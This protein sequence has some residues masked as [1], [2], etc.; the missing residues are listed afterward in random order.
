MSAIRG[1]LIR[2][3]AGTGHDQFRALVVEDDLDFREGLAHLV[4]HEGFDVSQAGTLHEARAQLRERSP[5]VVF[6]DLALPD[7]SGF[8]LLGAG[9]NPQP[10]FVVITG[11][12]TVEAVDRAL[13]HGAVDFLTKPVDLARL[14]A[15]LTRLVRRMG[16]F[17]PMLGRS[18]PMQRVYDLI[19]KIAP[20]QAGVLILGETGTGKELVAQ[21]VHQMSRRTAGPFVAVNCGAISPS[22]IES[23]LFGHERGSFTG[24]EH[25][26]KGY[27]EAAHGGTLL[28]DEITEMPVDLQVKLLRVIE[29]GRLMRV[30]ASEPVVVDVRVLAATNRDPERALRQGRL[31]EDLYWRLNVF[32]IEVPPLRERG[33]DI[34]MLA[35]HFLSEFN[36]REGTSKKWSERGLRKLAKYSWPG[37]VRE[38]RNVVQRTAIIARDVVD[39]P[40]LPE[41]EAEQ[42][43]ME[44]GSAL[45]IPVGTPLADVERRMILA[46][47]RM[48]RGDKPE[49]ARRLGISLKTLYTRLNL[50]QATGRTGV[51][52]QVEPPNPSSDG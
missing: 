4:A 2:R 22:V 9:P 21:T 28:L 29:S 10:D 36:L 7:G 23:E 11:T 5:G 17:G 8:D 43:P 3:A 26:R 15:I 32:Q 16:R 24:A 13:R 14:H 38:L 42:S 12:A 40:G 45:Q 50:Y 19:S 6:V 18:L 51:G 34:L 49:A 52:G 48:V 46:T 31:R 37:N 27:F 25:A 1:E 20:S 30:G 39:D 41:D 44:E 47:L 33:D 35:E